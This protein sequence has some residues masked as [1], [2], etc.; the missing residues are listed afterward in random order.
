M[1]APSSNLH[2]AVQAD[3]N[4]Y[5]HML[6][7]GGSNK[8]PNHLK[9]PSHQPGPKRTTKFT[10]HKSNP[11]HTLIATHNEPYVN[12]PSEPSNQLIPSYLGGA[13]RTPQ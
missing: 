7:F 8:P 1:A 9:T 4:L 13:T 12:K 6:I 3:K 2:K 10:K 5:N 11:E